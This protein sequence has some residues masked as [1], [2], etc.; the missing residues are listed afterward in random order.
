MAAS[1]KYFNTKTNFNFEHKT[2][3]E[4]EK[5]P[6]PENMIDELASLCDR[7]YISS[8]MKYLQIYYMRLNHMF[9]L[10]AFG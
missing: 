3:T 6:F 2:L 7:V 10:W 4:T 5:C 1:L 8:C 9:F